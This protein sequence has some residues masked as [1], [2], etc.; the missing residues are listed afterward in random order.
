MKKQSTD[1][2]WE[3]LVMFLCLEAKKREVVPSEE[4][5]RGGRALG[6]WRLN[7]HLIFLSSSL[8]L[9]PYH[10]TSIKLKQKKLIH[11]PFFLVHSTYAQKLNANF[12]NIICFPHV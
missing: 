6:T 3:G 5:G 1:S 11:Y 10:F 12:L 7:E 9:L 8:T 4:M 2:D